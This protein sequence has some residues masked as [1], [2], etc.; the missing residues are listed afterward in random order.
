MDRR[1]EENTF[2]LFYKAININ[3][4]AWTRKK[5]LDRA[6]GIKILNT[7]SANT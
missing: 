2:K 4:K 6:V 5:T 7:I 3:T 1:G